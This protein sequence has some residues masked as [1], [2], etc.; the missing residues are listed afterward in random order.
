MGIAVIV[1]G[2]I[3]V[4]GYLAMPE[5]SAGTRLRGVGVGAFFFVYGIWAASQ[6]SGLVLIPAA[7]FAVA[8]AVLYTLYQQWQERYRRR[9]VQPLPPGTPGAKQ[10]LSCGKAF[11]AETTGACPHCKGTLARPFSATTPRR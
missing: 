7:A 8:L 11:A 5:L 6:T 4:V 1:A 3:V 9:T 10:C 2:A